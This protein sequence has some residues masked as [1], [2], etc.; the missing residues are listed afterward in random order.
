[1]SAILYPN[2]LII[3]DG[4]CKFCN[5]SI[6]FIIRNDPNT[7]FCF[8]TAQSAAGSNILKQLGIDPND[9][10]T[11]VFLSHG[12]A[13][14]QSDA[15]LE[16]AKKLRAPWSYLIVLKVVPRFLRDQVYRFIAR[17]RYQILGKYDTCMI[18]SKELQSRFLD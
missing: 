1:M 3:F 11:F 18:P 12:V 4:V 16:I 10:T 15:A 8:A 9:P 2:E 5:A 6:N 13:H 17:R 14:L 7:V